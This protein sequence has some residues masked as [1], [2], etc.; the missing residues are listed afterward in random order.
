MFFIYSYSS[1]IKCFFPL[2]NSVL[3]IHFTGYQMKASHIDLIYILMN[4]N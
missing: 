3:Y 2:R 1:L 4:D